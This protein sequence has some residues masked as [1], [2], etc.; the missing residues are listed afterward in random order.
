VIISLKYCSR[1]VIFNIPIVLEDT[2]E[3]SITEINKIQ[4]LVNTL[5]AVSTIRSG[6]R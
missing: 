3:A 6:T 1:T 4:V 5:F 2:A